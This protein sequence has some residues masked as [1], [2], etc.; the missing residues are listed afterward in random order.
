MLAKK[1]QSW[2]ADGISYQRISTRWIECS[3]LSQYLFSISVWVAT[4]RTSFFLDE[5]VSISHS[6]LSFFSIYF[7]ISIILT[8]SSG[9][10]TRTCQM[11]LIK[12]TIVPAKTN[13]LLKTWLSHVGTTSIE[14]E[15]EIIEEKSNQVIIRTSGVL[16]GID[17]DSSSQII[18]R[19]ISSIET[20]KSLIKPK[21]IQFDTELPK[22]CLSLSN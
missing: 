12:E 22:R 21:I 16:V 1:E 15:H 4:G 2:F 6:K 13:L 17:F 10:L 5:S 9:L 11:E 20:M 8:N 3:S 18:K 14:Q 7:H 19:K